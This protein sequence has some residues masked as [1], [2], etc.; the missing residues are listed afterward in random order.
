[1]L[2]IINRASYKILQLLA[3][4]EKKAAIKPISHDLN[5]QW[6]EKLKDAER[7][8]LK[9]LL[10]EEISKS[11]DSEFQESI[12]KEHPN[13]YVEENDLVEKMNLK[14]KRLLEER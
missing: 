1:M 8:L 13:S 2:K 14:L 9:V 6:N 11:A 12:K 4:V 3:T 10:K 5:N 7:K